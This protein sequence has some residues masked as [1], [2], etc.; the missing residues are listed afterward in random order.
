[1]NLNVVLLKEMKKKSKKKR[2]L[3]KIVTHKL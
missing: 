2:K 3:D 1:M